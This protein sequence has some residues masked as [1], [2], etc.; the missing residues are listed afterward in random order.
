MLINNQYSAID[1]LVIIDASVRD[2]Q[3]L[4]SGLVRGAAAIPLEANKDGIVQIDEILA[5]YPNITSLHLVTHGNP[6]CIYLGNTELSLTTLDR[7]AES[8]A[9]WSVPQILLYGCRVAVGDA[10]AEFIE[11]LQKISGADIAASTTLTGN[12]RSGGNWLLEVT[13]R[14]MAVELAF[15]AATKEAYQHTLIDLNPDGTFDGNIFNTGY[16]GSGGQQDP[17]LNDLVWEVSELITAATPTESDPS[18]V[19]TWSPADV[20]LNEPGPWVDNPFGTADWISYRAAEA[21][22]TETTHTGPK[23]VYFRYRFDLTGFDPAAFALQLDFYADNDVF[24]IYVNGVAQ[25]T[26][27]NLNEAT[28]NAIT[29]NNG[30]PYPALGYIAGAQLSAELTE[31]W[32]DGANEIIVHVKSGAPRIGFLADFD[33][34]KI[35]PILDLDGDNS[36]GT[37]SEDYTN[38][39]TAGVTPVSIV[40]S[41]AKIIDNIQTDPNKKQVQSATFTLTN[42]QAGDDILVGTLPAGITASIDRSQSGRI[43][44][45]L[46]TASGTGSTT[47]YITAFQALQFNN[48]AG[49]DPDNTPRLIDIALTD[50]DGNISGTATS[51]INVLDASA[52]PNQPPTITSD[53]SGDT[54]TKEIPENTTEVTTVTST[55]PNVD[56]PTYSIVGGDD[57]TLFQ[58]DPATGVLSFVNPPDF[59]APADSDGNNIYTVQVQVA[60]G[61]GGFDV[62]TLTVNVGDVNETVPNLPPSI[63]SGNNGQPVVVSTPE[64][65]IPVPYQVAATDPDGDTLGYSINPDVGDG[66][67]FA[68]DFE[69]NISFVTPPDFEAPTDGDGNNSYTLQVSVSDGKGGTVTQDVTVNVTDIDETAPNSPPNITSGNNGQ[70]VV[71]STPENIIPVPYQV[72]AADPNGDPLTYSINPDVG[73]GLLFEIDPEGNISFA[74]PPDFEAPADSDGNNSYTLQVLVSDG[75]GGTTTQDVTV[76][77]TDI[78]DTAP[79]V[80]IVSPPPTSDTT[81]ALTGTVDNPNAAITVTI[82]GKDYPA[83][84]NGDGTWTIPDN[85]ID[86]LP[87]ESTY[88]TKVTAV[89][90]AG[91]IAVDEGVVTVDTTAPTVTVNNKRTNDGTPELTG[92]VDDPNAVVLVTVNGIEYTATNN[93]NTWTLPNDAI[94]P[95]LA[96]NTYDVTA[97]ATDPAGNAGTDGTTGELIVDATGIDVTLAPVNTPDTTPTLTGNVSKP[98]A[99]VSVNLNGTDYPAINNGNGTWT[100]PGEN[101]SP[102]LGDGTYPITVTAVDD[103][104]NTGFTDGSL[105][106]DN[107]PPAVTVNFLTTNDSTPVLTGT[108]NEPV[109]RLDVTVNGQTYPARVNGNT[110]VLANNLINPPL[111]DDIYSVTATATDLTGN[112][113]TDETEGELTIDTT[114]LNSPTITSPNVTGDTTPAIEGG[115]DPDTDVRVSL[116]LD[117]DGIPDVTYATRSDIEGNWS[118]DLE[119]ATPIVGQRPTLQNGDFLGVSAIT[120]DPLGNRSDRATQLLEILPLATAVDDTADASLTGNTQIDVL[121]NDTGDGLKILSFTPPEGG[122]EVTIDD[123]G[124]P[125]DPS[126]DRLLYTPPAAGFALERSG[127]QNIFRLVGDG[128]TPAFTDTFTYTIEDANGTQQTASVNVNVPAGAS[129]GTTALE[130]AFTGADALCRNEIGFFKVADDAG[131]IQV[132][133]DAGNVTSSVTPDD[134]EY[135]QTA[136]ESGRVIFTSFSDAFDGDQTRI[137]DGF[138]SDDRLNFFLIQNDSVDRVLADLEEGDSTVPVFFGTPNSNESAFNPTTISDLEDG[139]F[140]IDWE[141]FGSGSD[142]DY[143]DTG[144]RVRVTNESAPLGSDLQGSRESELLDL[145]ATTAA[146]TGTFQVSSDAKFNNTVGFYRV[147]DAS[148]SIF[149]QVTG[150][151]LN[152][153]DAGYAKVAVRQSINSVDRGSSGDTGTFEAGAIY[154]PVLVSNASLQDFLSQNPDNDQSNEEVVAYFNYVGANPDSADHIRLLGDNTFGFED[155]FQGG[156]LD[157]NDFIVKVDLV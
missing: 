148:G 97:V 71:V 10:G 106:I 56:T 115:A 74:T 21:G 157:F 132:T 104:G 110:W 7:Y 76:N 44:V 28:K 65:T 155:E 57:G 109:T 100:L 133:D 75:R 140:Q 118:I 8:I 48:T 120:L 124:T 38:T 113:G 77:V 151:V 87:G 15:D 1:R 129:G 138:S 63:T 90:E 59:E 96:S 66:R 131:T 26:N 86:P 31:N 156:D 127:G 32:V 73:D 134:P 146:T 116:D 54:A 139:G 152:P 46:T 85:T 126:D 94:A 53:G 98:D 19:T 39:F 25:S 43:V 119:T 2:S 47:D 79:A 13:T 91:N 117:N 12:D 42:A 147:E 14:D 144:V 6:G 68:I 141:D 88:P 93:G 137:I 51:T 29:S 34:T 153:G 121:A 123:N 20:V 111:P 5:L 122:G 16:N 70:P 80:S 52:P 143:D 145:S 23:D 92:T 89:D 72:T 50:G 84:N 114:P 30:N 35:E 4:I 128:N 67:L 36:S 105:T 112:V 99:D 40:D 83:I 61:R 108:V 103:L 130:F 55:D 22:Q 24:E 150:A 142:L 11:K 125:D 154:A 135:L 82:E 33:V 49:N 69:G 3:L 62:Q 18:K 9:S 41:D 149:D 64:N 27:A 60:D 136:L 102:P 58:I 101:V 45:T 37:P 81:P 107:L 78:D 17:S 95:A